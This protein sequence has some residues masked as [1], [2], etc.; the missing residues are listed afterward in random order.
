MSAKKN[1][2]SDALLGRISKHLYVPVV[3]DILDALG[4]REHTLR[5]DIRPLFP[6][7]RFVGR[8]ATALAVDIYEEPAKPY[9]KLMTAIDALTPGACLVGTTNGS[10]RGG[11]WGELL[12]TAVRARGAAG[13]VLD[14]ATR[15]T[16]AIIDMKFPVFARGIMSADSKGRVEVVDVGCPIDCGGVRVH[17]GDIVFGDHDGVVVVPQALTAEV[18]RRAEKK[19]FGENTVR[20]ALAGGMSVRAAFKKYGVL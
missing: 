8:A 18:V 1:P 2:V 10:M 4:V 11:L 5:H 3:C 13:V 12:S 6:E 15:D 17:P 14:G 16:L 7:A 19:V 20:K 9:D